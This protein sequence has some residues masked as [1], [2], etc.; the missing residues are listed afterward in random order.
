MN[1][2]ASTVRR[3]T[4]SIA[5]SPILL[6]T[7]AIVI[8]A[9]SRLLPHPPNFTPIAALGLF[10]GTIGSR[11]KMAVIAVV[12][13]MLIS[14]SLLGFHSMMPIV[15]LCL[16]ANVA[17][18]WYF[19]RGGRSSYSP[20]IGST[21]RVLGGALMGSVLFFLVTNFA[22]FA[23]FYPMTLAGLIACYTAA[24]PFLQYTVAGDLIY[25][26]LLFGVY[27]IANSGARTVGVPA[28]S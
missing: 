4:S 21:G 13:A 5:R 11:P 14:D 2:I 18:G 23:S 25:S 15:Y 26:G 6:M 28:R 22:V 1:Q 17:I 20:S 3:L 10:A 9:L 27:A 24:I 12:A 8:A 19:V 16:V 7:L